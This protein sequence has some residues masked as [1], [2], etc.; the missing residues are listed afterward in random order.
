M[1]GLK[2]TEIARTRECGL[3][4]QHF[5]DLASGEQ[6]YLSLHLLGSR[7]NIVPDDYFE[8][9]SKQ[10]IHDL[11]RTLISDFE[12][13]A[14]IFFEQKDEL[15]RALFVHLN[16]FMY[17]YKFGV[18]IG[19]V[20]GDDVVNEYP[21]LFALTRIAAKRLEENIGF[22]IPDGEIAYL[23][24]HFGAF[25]KISKHDND[26]LRILIVCVN[27][28][29]TGNMLKRE[30]Q[31]LLPFAENVDVR[32][33]VDM[34]NIQN[35]C[36]L[37][38][39]TVKINTIVPVITVHP[40]LT[41]FAV[42]TASIFALGM[43]FNLVLA[44]FSKLKYIFLTGHHALY[45][46][47][48]VAI[49]MSIAGLTGPQLII[50]GALLMGLVM[51]IFPALMRP[52]M[53]KV[54]G[55]DSLA[56]G[57]FGSGCYWLSAQIGKLFG[58]D[59]NTTT[60][61]DIKFPQGLSFL[62]ENTISIALAMFLCYIVVAC[63]RMLSSGLGTSFVMEMNVNK[64]LANLGIS[65]VEVSHSTIDDVMPGAADL[66]VCSADLVANAER[67]GQ[68][69]GIQNM[70]SVQEMEEKLKAAFEE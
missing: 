51:A 44:R 47:C 10:Y 62:R 31:K 26:R 22:P 60:T 16:T 5:P 43:C 49:L 23:A 30:I 65:G 53:C 3:V 56:L 69:V 67:A 57:H 36:D 4:W 54:V 70:M 39:S 6:I 48:L 32:A 15:E 35:I 8:S 41:E 2:E 12:K 38:I 46:S 33:A 29:S 59:E 20:I 55:N 45:M 17:R 18:Q 37:V 63:V 52:T 25:L 11:T 21:E 14:C 66:F 27:G 58:R 64:A 42:Q 50:T 13:V 7:V 1:E 40:I 61:E 34:V 24:L 19:N 28:I 9:N 68:A